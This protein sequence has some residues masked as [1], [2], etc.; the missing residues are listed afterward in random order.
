M[1]LIG[2]IVPSP[3]TQMLH[4]MHSRMSSSR[5]SSIFRG[6]NGSAIDGRAAPIMSS[7]PSRTIR[8]IVSGDVKRPTPTTGLDVSAFSPRTYSS[9]TASGANRDVDES[10][11]HSPTTK[12][13]TSG[14]SPT[15]P[16]TPSMSGRS[17]P[18]AP[19]SSSTVMRQ[20]TAARPSTSSRVSSSISRKSRARFSRLPP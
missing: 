2:L 19:T 17:I 11:S 18:S 4:P 3:D 5:P 7:T 10:F 1:H 8:T 14:S 20:A 12:S 9:W 6:R 16:S 13:Q 15:R